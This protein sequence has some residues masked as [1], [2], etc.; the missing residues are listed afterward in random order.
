M[1]S[2]CDKCGEYA[3]ECECNIDH[4]T[5][6]AMNAAVSLISQNLQENQLKIAF[7]TIK[8]SGLWDEFEDFAKDKRLQIIWD[9]II[10]FGKKHPDKFY[11][12]HDSEFPKSYT[13]YVVM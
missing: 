7:E 13:K 5:R 3:L 4:A 6:R 8:N 1:S 2:E 10:Q 9:T 11:V 12:P